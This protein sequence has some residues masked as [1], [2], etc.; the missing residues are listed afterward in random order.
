MRE[1]WIAGREFGAQ[2]LSAAVS[3]PSAARRHPQVDTLDREKAKAPD[4]ITFVLRVHVHAWP[5]NV[6]EN[7]AQRDLSLICS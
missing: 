1:R 2:V 6:G 5:G 7:V 4:R 3:L